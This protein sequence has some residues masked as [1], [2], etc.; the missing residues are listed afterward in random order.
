[1][2]KLRNPS[3]SSFESLAGVRVGEN[4]FEGVTDFTLQTWMQVLNK[5][6]DVR[7]DAE[8]MNRALHARN[9]LPNPCRAIT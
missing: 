9:T 2:R 4:L 8:L 5:T 3:S 7:W 1:M 6:G